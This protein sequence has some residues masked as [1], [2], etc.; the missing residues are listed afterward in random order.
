VAALS[1]SRILLVN[2]SCAL[3][4]RAKENQ[5]FGALDAGV[6]STENGLFLPS[7][8][9]PTGQNLL[10]DGGAFAGLL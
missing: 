1:R 8:T 5:S 10:I 3:K 2:P 6:K 7:V 9:V 4:D